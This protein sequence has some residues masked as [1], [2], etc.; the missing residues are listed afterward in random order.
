MDKLI[1]CGAALNPAPPC[2]IGSTALD[3]ARCPRRCVIENYYPHPV[4]AYPETPCAPESLALHSDGELLPLPCSL[5][6]ERSNLDTDPLVRADAER[7]TV[8]LSREI[9]LLRSHINSLQ[10]ELGR[11]HADLERTRAR[12]QALGLH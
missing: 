6:V 1:L 11:A 3:K 8:E 9:E 2:M 5:D 4:E 12:S 7:R 10:S